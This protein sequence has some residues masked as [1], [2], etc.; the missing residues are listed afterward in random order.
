MVCPLLSLDILSSSSLNWYWV[1]NSPNPEKKM[2]SKVVFSLWNRTASVLVSGRGGC[3][4]CAGSAATSIGVW[5]SNAAAAALS[6]KRC[7]ACCPKVSE[8]L[9]GAIRGIDKGSVAWGRVTR[10]VGI[11]SISYRLWYSLRSLSFKAYRCG[12]R[13]LLYN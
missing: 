12:A 8:A 13:W 2:T 5:R 10:A 6:S 4:L 3:S 9:C 11:S 1:M 7:R